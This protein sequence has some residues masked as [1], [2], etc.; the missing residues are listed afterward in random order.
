MSPDYL[1]IVF[2]ILGLAFGFGSGW[3]SCRARLRLSREMAEEECLALRRQIEALRIDH[4]KLSE[5]LTLAEE[6]HRA[7]AEEYTQERQFN[8]SLHAELSRERTTRVHL[9]TKLEQQKHE[10]LQLQERLS[11]DFSNLVR[12]TL[13][14]KSSTLTDENKAKLA[15]LIQPILDQIR[16][17]QQTSEQQHNRETHEL[18]VLHNKLANLEAKRWPEPNGSGLIRKAEVQEDSNG[19]PSLGPNDLIEFVNV[20]L[21]SAFAQMPDNGESGP[22][23]TDLSKKGESFHPFTLKQEVEIDNFLKRTIHRVGRKKPVD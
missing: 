15:P 10:F 18:L 20:P 14:E 7:E 21:E 23:G 8:V 9:E 22:A 12:Q 1:D 19:T 16:E 6:R 17:F 13:D 11:R 5:R 2:L 4:A 3:I